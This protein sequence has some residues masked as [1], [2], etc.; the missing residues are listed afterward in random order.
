MNKTLLRLARGLW[1]WILAIAGVSFLTLVGTTALAEIIAGFLGSLFEPQEALSSAGSAIRGALLVALFTFCAQMGKGLLE[2]KTAAEARTSMRR[3]IFSRVL[4]L[5]AGG[6]EKIGPVSAITASVDAVEQM[7]MYFSTY[8][9]SLICSIL[10]P[11]YLFFHLK[12]ISMPV[13]LL[14]LAV[15]LVLLPV[16]NLFRCRIEQIRKTYWKSLDDMTG[17]YMDSLRGLTTL[18][19]FDRDQEHSR[20]LGEKADILNYNINCF[21]KVN[22]T[23]FLVTEAMIYAAILFALVNSAGRIADG[24]MTIAQALIVLMLS[25]SYFSAAKELMNAS[26]SAL[27]AIAAAGKVEEILDTDTSRP[28]DPALPADPKQFEGIRMDHVSYGY[29]GRS[30]ALQDISLTVPKGKTVA[31]VGLSGCGKSTTASL[32]MRFCDPLSGNIYIEGKDYCSMKPEELRKH[33]AMVPQQV[34]LFSGTI[35]ENLLLADPGAKDAALL[36][37]LEE[38][39]LGAFIR[40]QSKGLDSDVGNAGSSLSGGQRQKMGI[41]RALLSKAEYMIFDEATSSVDPQSEK[42]I[43]ETIGHLAESRTLIIISHRMSSVQNADC[44]YVLRDGRVAQHGT[45]E[46]LMAEGGLYKELVV[47]QQAME[48]AE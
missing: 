21:M 8:L 45:H 48:V 23:S 17:Y 35:R 30:R 10:A 28:Y 22:F 15:S 9:P 20:I 37:A 38:A 44:I 43:W 25:Y 24:S 29:E 7:Q 12:N 27:T 18:K 2:Y 19:L 39:G 16:N 26:H 40:S 47:R 4:E 41:A 1:L 42:E 34:N 14:L 11:V 13:A 31:M 33:I 6:I 32:L 36:E 5:D 3:M 46:A